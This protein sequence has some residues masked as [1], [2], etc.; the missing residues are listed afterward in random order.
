MMIEITC[1]RPG[2]RRAGMAHPAKAV[3]PAKRFSRAEL[4]A[5]RAEPLLTVC[6]LPEPKESDGAPRPDAPHNVEL[7]V[8]FAVVPVAQIVGEAQAFDLAQ[9]VPVKELPGHSAKP[10]AK[11]RAARATKAKKG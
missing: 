4:A 6:E 7:P 8:E 1:K 10:A 3:Y 5:L 11:P 2:F 9:G